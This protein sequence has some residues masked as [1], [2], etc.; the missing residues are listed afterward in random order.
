M[1]FLR[2]NFHGCRG[3]YYLKSP[4]ELIHEAHDFELGGFS[5]DPVSALLLGRIKGRI[6][7]FE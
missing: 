5:Y 3:K 6:S 7:P 1:T 2:P 4:A